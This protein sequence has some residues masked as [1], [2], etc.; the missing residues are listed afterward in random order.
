MVLAAMAKNGRDF[1]GDP[2]LA[3][4]SHIGFMHHS[5]SL[6]RV[7]GPLASHLSARDSPQFLI[8]SRERGW[9]RLPDCPPKLAQQQCNIATG[10]GITSPRVWDCI[11]PRGGLFAQR[12]RLPAR[13]CANA[14]RTICGLAPRRVVRHPGFEET[15][16]GFL[17]CAH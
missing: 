4:Q 17:K 10:F 12:F 9:R 11:S 5:G 6:K 15:G 14:W 8:K 13:T 3:S 1:A 7:A 2:L 16:P